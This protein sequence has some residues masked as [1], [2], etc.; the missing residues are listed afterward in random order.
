MTK[1]NK[2]KKI[3]DTMMADN[4]DEAKNSLLLKGIDK[5]IADQRA[6]EI[7]KAAEGFEAQMAHQGE[8]Q[9]AIAEQKGA[10]EELNTTF[11]NG[12][13]DSI[14]TAVEGT[15]SLKDSLLGVIKSMAKFAPKR[16]TT[17]AKKIRIR[18]TP[19]EFS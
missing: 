3:M 6:D 14:L 8:L 9:Q 4:D 11:R 1:A 2:G 16:T 17:V 7:E 15:K 10:Y 18:L 13:V 12:I 5:E 19:V